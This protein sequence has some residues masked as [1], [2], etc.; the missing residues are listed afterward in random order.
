M[1][2]L[3]GTI[4]TL[5]FACHYDTTTLDAGTSDAAQVSGYCERWQIAPAPCY[6]DAC[7][8]GERVCG[9]ERVC[10]EWSDCVPYGSDAAPS[11]C[12]QC[13]QLNWCQCE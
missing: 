6:A 8:V 1:R 2:T 9:A 5:S 7:E 13:R 10:K 3:L 4:L 12:F 11:D